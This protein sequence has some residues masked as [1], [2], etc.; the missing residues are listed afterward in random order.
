MKAK[1]FK[2]LS[3]ACLIIATTSSCKKEVQVGV[4][5]TQLVTTSVFSNDNTATAAQLSIY[6]QMSSFP[7]NV[8]RS[9]ALSSDELTNYSADMTSR[10]M[11]KN[12]L[13]AL[14][15][16]GSIPI[17]STAYNYI[18][19][20]NAIHENLQGSTA[21]SAKVKQQLDAE[22]LFMRAYFYFYLV[23]F[24][25]DVPLVTTTDYKINAT[26]PRTSKTQV[27][28][29]IISDLKRAQVSLNPDY[30]DATDTSVTL[31]HIR[32]TTWAATAL[33]ARAYLYS[34]KYDSA[35]MQ[36]TTI[37]SSPK[38]KLPADL[39]KVFLKNSDEAIW[40][41]TP[42][43]A[44][45]CTADGASLILNAAPNAS[46][47]SNSTTV[48]PQL[49]A[50]FE[51]G[52]Q[53][54]SVW[55]N[56]Y[57]SGANTWNFPYKYRD[58]NNATTL[59]EYTMMLRLAEQYL[60]RAEARIQQGNSN[61]AIADLNVIRNRA[62]L[63]NYAGTTDQTA[64]LAA[65]GHERQ[66]ELFTEGDRWSDLKRTKNIDIVMGG[67]NGACAAKGGAWDT[68]QQLYP[69]IVTDIQNNANLVQNSG[70]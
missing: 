3:I 52:D 25:G 10:D 49:M 59:K 22:A 39:T 48:S 11:Y 44:L 1:Y 37:I 28:Q 67:L 61:G 15:D 42:A 68:N 35:E 51:T 45:F 54:K 14:L 65:I 23:N 34:G 16:A 43:S 36:A 64:I 38:F 66:V 50:A 19:Q 12:A 9:T 70:Y 63:S 8:H 26:L 13:S 5:V 69:L 53:R 62:G 30:V 21:I 27:Y 58:N 55:I 4:P 32:P 46:S 33:M 6:A 29:Q 56:S 7:W 20:V 40:Q 31:D 47:T 60:I 18:Y 41:L 17:W 24:Y 2:S 57:T